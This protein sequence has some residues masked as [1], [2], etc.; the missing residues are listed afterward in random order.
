VI[1][2]AAISGHSLETIHQILRHYLA[3]HPDQARAAIGQLADWLD[4]QGAKL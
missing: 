1:R 2:I 3:R 4:K